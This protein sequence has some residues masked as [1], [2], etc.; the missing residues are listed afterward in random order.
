MQ[1][2][3]LSVYTAT[4][5]LEDYEQMYIVHSGFAREIK[6]KKRVPLRAMKTFI[7]MKLGRTT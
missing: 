2:S 5:S 6:N 4:P 1:N 7:R 3:F